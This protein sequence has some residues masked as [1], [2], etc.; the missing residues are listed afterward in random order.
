MSNIE[1]RQAKTEDLNVI[2]KIIITSWLSTY[3]N[4]TLERP[5]TEGEIQSFLID[6]EERFLNGTGN[7]INK[8]QLWLAQDE[9]RIIGFAS[10][11]IKENTGQLMQIYILPE[12]IGKGIGK[13]LMEK[14]L[15]FMKDC[16][17]VIVEC[18]SYN[19]RAINFY[20]RFGF[21]N[22]EKI[23]DFPLNERTSIPQIRLTR[24]Q[25]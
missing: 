18:A 8:G 16:S 5:I 11:R 20:K 9:N 23:E 10:A 13:L 21:G 22:E 14:V 4:P 3:P 7:L 24:K 6:S 15:D 1:I 12:F 19:D 17:E 25:K 2:H